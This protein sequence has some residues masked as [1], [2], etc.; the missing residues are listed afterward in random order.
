MEPLALSQ[1][2]ANSWLLSDL[3]SCGQDSTDPGQD[4]HYDISSTE[5]QTNV[6]THTQTH[7]KPWKSP[8]CRNNG[9]LANKL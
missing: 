9:R 6:Y 4:K 7:P 3:N 8:K 5:T 1:G 2:L